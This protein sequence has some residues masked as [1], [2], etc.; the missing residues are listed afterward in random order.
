MKFI[1]RYMCKSGF[2]CEECGD[3]VTKGSYYFTLTN[4]AD[5]TVKCCASC[6][7]HILAETLD[8]VTWSEYNDHSEI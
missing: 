3:Y 6:A 2:E 7:A 4:H 1:N 8:G 5:E